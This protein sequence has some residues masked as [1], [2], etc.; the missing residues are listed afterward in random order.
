L[1]NWLVSRCGDLQSD[2]GIF[3]LPN[4]LEGLS[5]GRGMTSFCKKG[6]EPFFSLRKGSSPFFV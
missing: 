5:I 1:H 6:L 4:V 3:R 2:K